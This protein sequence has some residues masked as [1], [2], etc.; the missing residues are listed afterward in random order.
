MLQ[1]LRHQVH[2]KLRPPPPERREQLLP[3]RV[4]IFTTL[5]SRSWQSVNANG[6]A[7]FVQ[8]GLLPPAW[9]SHQRSDLNLD[10]ERC[11]QSYVSMRRFSQGVSGLLQRVVEVHKLSYQRRRF[12]K[13]IKNRTVAI[14]LSGGGIDCKSVSTLLR[15]DC[16]SFEASEG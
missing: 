3:C 16:D 1:E 10:P 2:V 11:R 9:I 4:Q 5:G 15:K 8:T 12:E 7:S 14:P 6:A 13:S